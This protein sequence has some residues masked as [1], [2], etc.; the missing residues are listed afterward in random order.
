MTLYEAIFWLISLHFVA[1]F[2]LQSDFISRGKSPGS[3]AIWPIVLSAHAAI[4]G[5]MVAIIVGPVLG[6]AEFILHWLVDLGKSSGVFG[7]GVGGFYF[8]QALHLVSKFVWIGLAMSG[9]PTGMG[10]FG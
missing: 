3:S 7:R 2:Q 1:D 10:L 8:D 5:V 4:H 6:L 9:V